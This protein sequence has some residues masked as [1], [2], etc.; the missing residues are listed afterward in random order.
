MWSAHGE[1]QAQLARTESGGSRIVL[2]A[3]DPSTPAPERILGYLACDADCGLASRWGRPLL[4]PIAPGAAD[5]GYA[6]ALDAADGTILAHTSD[7]ASAVTGC[8]VDC[9]TPAGRWVTVPGLTTEDLDAAYPI[10]LPASCERAG[11]SIYSGPA[12]ALVDAR[13]ITA[14]TASA[15][16]Y[17][18][19]CENG[20]TIDTVSF[21]RFVP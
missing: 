6:V 20:T 21:V 5:T 16:A 9:T 8:A 7:S 18:G 12:L 11:W 19:P 14:V 10:T 15:T 2:Y 3:D 4:P 17:G 1:I 13:P